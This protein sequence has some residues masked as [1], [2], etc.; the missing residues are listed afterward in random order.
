MLLLVDHRRRVALSLNIT[1]LQAYVSIV[2]FVFLHPAPLYLLFD[3]FTRY[4]E[5]KSN[6]AAFTDSCHLQNIG[7]LLLAE[8]SNNVGLFA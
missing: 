5:M 6:Y 8:Q 4:T 3:L 2:I 7:E 1:P